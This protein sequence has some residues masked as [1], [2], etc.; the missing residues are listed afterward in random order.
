MI[1]VLK[2][3]LWHFCRETDEMGVVVAKGSCETRIQI[4]EARGSRKSR[5]SPGSPLCLLRDA[6]YLVNE[7]TN[8]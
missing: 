4:K 6:Q 1:H 8:E 5:T 7:G 3:S 2:A